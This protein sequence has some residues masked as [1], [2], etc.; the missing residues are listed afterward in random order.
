MD[1]SEPGD[2]YQDSAQ[3]RE[4]VRFKGTMASLKQ[5]PSMCL[6]NPATH[7]AYV[8]VTVTYRDAD[9]TLRTATPITAELCSVKL[10]SSMGLK[11]ADI[12]EWIRHGESIGR[13]IYEEGH[14]EALWRDEKWV[15]DD[16]LQEWRRGSSRPPMTLSDL[17][18][19]ARKLR[20]WRRVV[21]DPTF[22]LDVTLW[23]SELKGLLPIVPTAEEIAAVIRK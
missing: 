10:V 9:D 1:F 21:C 3:M 7:E 6:T 12:T 4:R 13:S 15:F 8:V 22:L 14:D 20:G 2:S 18:E 19:L 11:I 5:Y 16:E 23:A 17:E